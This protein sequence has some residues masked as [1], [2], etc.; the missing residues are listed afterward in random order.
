M[1]SHGV[2]DLKSNFFLA[3]REIF[4]SGDKRVISWNGNR[5][6]HLRLEGLYMCF[7]SI[8]MKQEGDKKNIIGK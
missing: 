2:T 7:I 1:Q 8:S 4:L 3:C 6:N 5:D